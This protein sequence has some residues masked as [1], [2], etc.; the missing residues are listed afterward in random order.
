MNFRNQLS[1]RS[2]DHLVS[3]ILAAIFIADYFLCSPKYRPHP[4]QLFRLQIVRFVVQ[5][6]Q[7]EKLQ[8]PIIILELSDGKQ[9]VSVCDLAVNC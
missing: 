9:D 3:Y 2:A 7:I 5:K 1:G 4:V 6:Q 8:R